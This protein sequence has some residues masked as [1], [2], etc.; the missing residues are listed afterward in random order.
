MLHGVEVTKAKYTIQ[1]GSVIGADLAMRIVHLM[2]I[3]D[4]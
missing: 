2:N 4:R 1:D 3:G